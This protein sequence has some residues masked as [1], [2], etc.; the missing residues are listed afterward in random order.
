MIGGGFSNTISGYASSILG[1]KANTVCNTAKWSSVV[2]GQI[3]KV[4]GLDSSVLSGCK[5]ISTGNCSV[6]L[7]G[8]GSCDNG[9]NY[10]GVFGCN[11][12]AVAANTFH[13]E[14]LNAVNTP[15]APGGAGVAPGGIYWD[16]VGSAGKA[17]YI[18]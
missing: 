9:F 12:V 6:V 1:G 3:N 2:G 5:N 15:F 7:G 10:A 13:T 18:K 8:S 17:L 14:C 11:V 4:A 16:V